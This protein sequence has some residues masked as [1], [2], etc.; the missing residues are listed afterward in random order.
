MSTQY[1]LLCQSANGKRIIFD[2]TGSHTATHFDD[3]PGLRDLATELLAGMELNEP[4]IARDVDLGRT[5][6]NTDVVQV[7]ESDEI[8]YAMRKYREDQGFVPFTKSRPAEP[9]NF[10]SIYLTRCDDST[11]EL[12]SAWI[13][14]YE[15]PPFPQM[16]NATAESIP[17]WD[18]HAFVWGSQETIAGTERKDCPW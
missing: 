4:I 17:Y 2:P 7:N 8:V 5:I 9:S 12:Q 10:V 3:A 18:K 16:E 11:Y 15:S 14:E 6:G 13:G 1:E